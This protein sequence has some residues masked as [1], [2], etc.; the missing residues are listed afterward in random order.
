M[1]KRG[2]WGNGDSH[3][4]TVTILAPTLA[5]QDLSMASLMVKNT[6]RRHYPEF[7][8]EDWKLTVKGEKYLAKVKFLFPFL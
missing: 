5:L 3:G 7:V 1:V 6:I 4:N 8:T 2:N